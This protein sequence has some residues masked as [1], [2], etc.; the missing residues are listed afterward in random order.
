LLIE[1]RGVIVIKAHRKRGCVMYMVPRPL[2]AH[3]LILSGLNSN[4]S[5]KYGDP[6]LRKLWLIA[7]PLIKIDLGFE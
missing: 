5:I 6:Q 1:N 4:Q 7:K 3:K 2:R